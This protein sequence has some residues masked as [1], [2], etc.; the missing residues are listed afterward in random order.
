[1]TRSGL[2]RFLS[3][4]LLDVSC[5]DPKRGGFVAGHLGAGIHGTE[6]VVA[7]ILREIER[8]GL[9]I[10]DADGKAIQP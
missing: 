3:E 8:R 5:L 4:Y 1:M 6:S 10:V 7:W 2:I 9:R